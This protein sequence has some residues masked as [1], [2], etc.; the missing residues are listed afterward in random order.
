MPVQTENRSH[1]Y[2]EQIAYAKSLWKQPF[3]QQRQWTVREIRAGCMNATAAVQFLLQAEAP[4]RGLQPRAQAWVRPELV[5][6]PI[7]S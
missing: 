2:I 7:V 4:W 3:L 5:I 1:Q 6:T